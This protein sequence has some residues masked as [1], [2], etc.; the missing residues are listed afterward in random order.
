MTRR[1]CALRFVC[2][3]DARHLDGAYTNFGQITEGQDV[4]DGIKVGD[5]IASIAIG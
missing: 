5:K 3:G 4:A 1:M 2:T